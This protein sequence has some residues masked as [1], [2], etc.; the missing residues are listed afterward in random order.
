MEALHGAATVSEMEARRAAREA[1][2]R[3]RGGR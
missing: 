2:V 3:A 1:E